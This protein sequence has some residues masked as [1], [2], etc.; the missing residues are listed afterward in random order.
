MPKIIG[1]VKI[2]KEGVGVLTYNEAT[3]SQKYFRGGY[4][5]HSAPLTAVWTGAAEDDDFDNADN[6]TCTNDLGNELA[7]AVPDATT[8]SYILAADADWTA[9][10]ELDIDGATIDLAGHTLMAMGVSGAGRVSDTTNDARAF[11][12]ELTYL[13]STTVGKQF[14]DTGYTHDTR[15]NVRVKFS[16]PVYPSGLEYFSF[17][18]GGERGYA[19]SF[20]GWM[21]RNGSSYNIYRSLGATGADWYGSSAGTVYNLFIRKSTAWDS[22]NCYVAN[23]ANNKV[24]SSIQKAR[25]RDSSLR[26]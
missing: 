15:A 16:H 14:I 18:G 3:S 8:T 21:H 7:G 25:T 10:G 6:W 24:L 1:D 2:I 23:E 11:Y 4:E 12:K 20:G 5:D 19:H 22:G 26:V 17:F 9:K 13:Q